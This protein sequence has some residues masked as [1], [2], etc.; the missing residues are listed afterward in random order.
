MFFGS[1]IFRFFG[2]LLILVVKNILALIKGRKGTT[3]EDV[4]SLSKYSDAING[5]S[6]EMICIVI[7]AVFL[8]TICVILM[9]F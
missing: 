6:Y 8:L 3:F 1:I 9:Q 7:G 5:F 4:W 2:V